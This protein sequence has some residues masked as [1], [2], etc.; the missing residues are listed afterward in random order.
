MDALAV[1]DAID[2]AWAEHRAMIEVA[3][4][5]STVTLIIHSDPKTGRPNQVEFQTRYRSP[6]TGGK[7]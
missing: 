7:S 1:K 4:M 3:P 6:R 2:R 5:A